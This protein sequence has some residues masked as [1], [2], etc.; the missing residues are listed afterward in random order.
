MWHPPH[1]WSKRPGDREDHVVTPIEEVIPY[2]ANQSALRL[3]SWKPWCWVKFGAWS[4]KLVILSSEL[5]AYETHGY[6]SAPKAEWHLEYLIRQWH[7]DNHAAAEEQYYGIWQRAQQ[8]NISS[9]VLAQLPQ[10]ALA[11]RLVT[12]P[13][14]TIHRQS[15]IKTRLY[16]LHED[17]AN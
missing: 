9:L 16:C 2:F 14:N 6:L 13:S 5:Y 17:K 12:L 8:C 11:A 3:A 1:N 10:T 15:L 4:R 7:L